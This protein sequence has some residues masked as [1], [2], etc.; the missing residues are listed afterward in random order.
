MPLARSGVLRRLSQALD[1]RRRLAMHPAPHALVALYLSLR[2]HCHVSPQARISWPGRVRLGRGARLYGCRIVARG[3]VELGPEVELND[4]ALLDTQDNGRI[5]IGARSAI[6][7]FTVIYGGGGVAIGKDCSIAGQSMIASTTHITADV[8]RTIRSQGNTV[9][10][11]T[12]EDDIWMGAN[13][14]V[15]AGAVI[16]HGTIIGANSLVRG[17]IP[18]MVLA[19]GAPIRVIRPR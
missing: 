8:T 5:T 9:A 11:I 14:T 13:C 19:A 15:L 16:G 17:T 1:L 2:W 7:P 18:P 3:T 6:G 10:P 4:F 12:I